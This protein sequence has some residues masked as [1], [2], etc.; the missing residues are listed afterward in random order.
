MRQKAYLINLGTGTD[1]NLLPLAS[2][3]IAAYSNSLPEIRDHYDLEVRMMRNRIE[4]VADE[5][6]S[7]AVVGFSSYCWNILGNRRLATM[8]RERFPEATIVFGGPSIPT[9]PERVLQFLQEHPA[10]D[11]LVHGEGELTFADLLQARLAGR[12]LSSVHGLSFRG[13]PCVTTPPRP[14]IDDFSGLPSPFLDGTF[15]RLLALYGD[16]IVGALWETNRGCPYYCTFCDW[17]SALVNKVTKLDLERLRM[18]LEWV[19]TRK[20]GYV[21]ATDA[22]FGIF[23]ERDLAIAQMLTSFT[24]STGYP[25]HFVLNWT[26]NSHQSIIDIARTSGMPA[27]TL[28]S[29]CRSSRSI[30]RPWRSSSGET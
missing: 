11:V 19:A 4:E 27:Y 20:L 2:G 29:R 22:N 8:C 1:R 10:V 25:N 9:R 30:R 21:Y 6:E 23:R 28:M 13:D 12:P 18:E 26:K 17:G 15:D 7:P 14:R 3:L 16:A 5:L 24:R